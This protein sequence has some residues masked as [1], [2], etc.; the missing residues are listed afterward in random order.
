[1]LPLLLLEQCSV[2]VPLDHLQF[3]LQLVLSLDASDHAR[4]V[5]LDLL[6]DLFFL[7]QATDLQVPSFPTGLQVQGHRLEDGVDVHGRLLR[8]IAAVCAYLAG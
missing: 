2:V 4:I 1:M 5:V 8:V 3:L 7:C 6:G